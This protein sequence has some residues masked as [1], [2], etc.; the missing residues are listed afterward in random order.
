MFISAQKRFPPEQMSL[1]SSV[2]EFRDQIIW[3]QK[4][5]MIFYSWY[6]NFYFVLIL[7]IKHFRKYYHCLK[8]VFFS[9][10]NCHWS[11]AFLMRYWKS[12]KL[13]RIPIPLSLQ[14]DRTSIK[15]FRP[16]WLQLFSKDFCKYYESKHLKESRGMFEIFCHCWSQDRA[17]LLLFGKF[18]ASD[19]SQRYGSLKWSTLLHLCPKCFW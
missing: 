11:S 18:L 8:R 14:P 7:N 16:A 3:R 15:S 5:T 12:I 17:M 9:P 10:P 1:L 4:S 19:P 13:Q 6:L 2:M